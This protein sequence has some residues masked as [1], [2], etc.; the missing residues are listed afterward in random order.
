MFCS[1]DILITFSTRKQRLVWSFEFD[2]RIVA[3]MNI[4]VKAQPSDKKI[5]RAIQKVIFDFKS[6]VQSLTRRP[7]WPLLSFWFAI[8]QPSKI[9]FCFHITLTQFDLYFIYRC[10]NS[11]G[12]VLNFSAIQV[13]VCT[14]K[15]DL[16]PQCK[17]ELLIIKIWFHMANV[18]SGNLSS[19]YV[20]LNLVSCFFNGVNHSDNCLSKLSFL[21]VL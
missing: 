20:N 2:R 16:S 6:L 12:F 17:N 4:L 18:C 21:Y 9:A 11:H 7:L 5:E 1:G 3:A 8:Y 15:F 10:K 19:A 14:I 13:N